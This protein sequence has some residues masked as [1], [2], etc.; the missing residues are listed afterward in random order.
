MRRFLAVLLLALPA[1]PSQRISYEAQSTPAFKVGTRLVE[2]FVVAR[3]KRGPL[4]DLSRG[5]FTLLDNGQP[6]AI[7]FFSAGAERVRASAPALRTATPLPPGTVSNRPNPNE[8]APASDTVLLLD[9]VFT[10]PADQVFVGEG[11]RLL[12]GA[13]ITGARHSGQK[14]LRSHRAASRRRA[15]PQ[16]SGLDHRSLPAYHLQ[17]LD[18]RGFPAG[19]E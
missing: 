19:Y 8:E 13:H 7:A 18:L 10:P 5:D 6:R 16:E 11:G 17:Q 1:T 9:Q 15:G 14:L 3:D 12:P 4:A 2:V